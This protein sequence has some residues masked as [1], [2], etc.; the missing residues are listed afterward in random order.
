[1]LNTA[2]TTD[3]SLNATAVGK[4]AYTREKLTATTACAQR[5]LSG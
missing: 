4:K 2:S 3:H 5:L 1:M